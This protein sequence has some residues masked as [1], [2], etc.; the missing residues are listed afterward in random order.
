MAS[1]MMSPIDAYIDGTF[2]SIFRVREI[3]AKRPDLAGFREWH[4]EETAANPR[5]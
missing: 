3:E 2:P 1:P 4:I 5:P